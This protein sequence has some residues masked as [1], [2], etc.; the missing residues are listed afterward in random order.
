MT[1]KEKPAL[2][3]FL[4]GVYLTDKRPMSIRPDGFILAEI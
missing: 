3:G 2:G 1:D 4:A